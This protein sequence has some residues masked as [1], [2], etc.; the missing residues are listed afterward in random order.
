MTSP[1]SGTKRR[2]AGREIVPV[3]LERAQVRGRAGT[4]A[5]T[6]SCCTR[7]ASSASTSP[8]ASVAWS[9]RSSRSWTSCRSWRAAA[10][11][12]PGTSATSAATTGSLATTSPR[13]STSCGTRT[14]TSSSPRPSRSRPGAAEKRRTD[15]S[16]P[17][18]GLFFRG[19]QLRLEH[20]GGHDLRRR[21][22]GGLAALPR[23]EERLQGHRYLVRDGN[24]RHRLTRISR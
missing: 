22:G 20:A 4:L 13:R 9:C 3:L 8:S 19:G 7:P 17:E 15:S 12:R 2:C 23:A 24:D 21:E 1:G 16:S 18:D 6:R 5:R 11:R 14:L 10:R